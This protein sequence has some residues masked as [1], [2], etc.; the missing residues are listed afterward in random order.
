MPVTVAP[1]RPLTNG[2]AIG[3]LTRLIPRDLV[4]EVLVQTG[5]RE[6]RSRLLPARVVVYYVLAMCLF[7]ED[8]YE[9]VMRK[10]VCGLQFLTSWRP[11]WQVPTTGAISQARQR[12]GESPLRML[13]ARVARPMAVAGTAG[14]WFHGWR[15]MAVDGV[16]LDVPETTANLEGFGKKAHRGGAAPYPQVRVVGLGE[17]GTHAIVA[18][19]IGPWSVYERELLAEIVDEIEPGMLVLADRGYFSYPLWRSVAATGAQ[20]LWRISRNLDVA[21]QA[22]L[23]DGSYLS[24]L[25]PKAMKA[26]LKRGKRFS[27]PEH[28]RV[29]VR[30]VEYTLTNRD[31]DAEPIRLLTTILDHELAPAVEL[32]ALYQQRWEF[33]LTLDEIETHQMAHH[34]LLRSKSPDLIRQEIWGLLL[35]HYAVRHLMHEAA[36]S[37]DSDSDLDVDRLSFVRSLNIVR[38]NVIQQVGFSP[39]ATESRVHT[40]HR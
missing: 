7:C 12:L 17:C 13:F 20:L 30:V 18:A 19:A 38:R 35:T 23:P 26:D 11:G 3:V 37:V 9:E 8:A 40:S 36:T 16:T 4:D 32:A 15:V 21:V 29:P 14:A 1:L 2:I 39:S 5:R 24:E 34:K 25:T 10:L 33:E 6:K 31:D 22:V 27:I 28:L